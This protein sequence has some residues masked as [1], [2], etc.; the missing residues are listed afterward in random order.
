MQGY[1]SQPLEALGSEPMALWGSFAPNAALTPVA[2]SNA[3]PPG[4]KAF[5]TAYAATGAF[6]V[7]LPAGCTPVGTPQIFVSAQCQDLT[8]HFQV[9]VTG[10]YSATNRTFTIQAHRN[11][12]GREVAAHA[13]ARIHFVLLFN[14]STGA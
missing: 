1:I 7:A 10:A 11:G 2:A 5:T 14:N 3:G 6:T 13:N 9:C 12:T 8:E 4:L